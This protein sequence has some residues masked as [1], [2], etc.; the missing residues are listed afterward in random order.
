MPPLVSIVT[1]TYNREDLLLELVENVRRQTY[2]PLE[3]V[4]VHDGPNQRLRERLR[5]EIG[6]GDLLGV[7][8]IFQELGFQSTQFLAYSH[9]ASPFMVAQLLARG[10]LQCWVSDDESMDPGHI[11]GLVDLLESGNH[12]FAYSRCHMYF[13]GT[14]ESTWIAGT[15]PQDGSQCT[16]VVYRRELLDYKTFMPH[17]GDGHDYLSVMS[18]IAAGASYAMMPEATF[19]HRVDKPNGLGAETR[20]HRQPLRG[21]GMVG[22]YAGPRWNGFEIDHRGNIVR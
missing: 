22:S 9:A 5:D 4:I 2:R 19:T 10:E 8:I 7:P 15:Y 1:G 11:S 16:G 18:W 6:N 13:K 17:I 21:T 12:D 14:P 3:H 20:M